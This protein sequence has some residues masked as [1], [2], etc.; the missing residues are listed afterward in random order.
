MIQRTMHCYYTNKVV[1]FA[2]TV[3]KKVEAIKVT[4]W[5]T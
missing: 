4:K 2:E 5:D 3:E 1:I